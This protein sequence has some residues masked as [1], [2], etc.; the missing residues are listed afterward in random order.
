MR[1]IIIS[2]FIVLSL[3]WSCSGQCQTTAS[4]VGKADTLSNDKNLD[5]LQKGIDDLTKSIKLQPDNDAA[6]NMRGI[7]Y[8]SMGRNQLAIDDFSKAIQ[9]NP[10]NAEYLDNRGRVYNKIKRYQQAIKDFDKAILID[11]G[12]AMFYI[13]RGD[14]HLKH[15]DKKI[16]CLDAKRACELGN[17]ALLQKAKE[18]GFCR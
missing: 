15:G 6:Y 18:K 1:R 7:I 10:T 9:L 16:G 5:E 4:S 2:M 13:D 14:I 8:F 12:V 3:L 11:A 17:C